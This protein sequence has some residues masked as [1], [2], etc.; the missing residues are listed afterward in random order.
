MSTIV[1]IVFDRQHPLELIGHPLASR[2]EAVVWLDDQWE[3]LGCET[4][5]PMG[6]VLL[7]DKIVG[8]A[9]QSGERGFAQADWAKAYVDAV[10]TVLDRP[11]VR[12]DVAENIVG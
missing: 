10:A 12:V 9:R 6:K 7:L 11:A 2:Q 5:N 8:I 4:T 1:T 3:E